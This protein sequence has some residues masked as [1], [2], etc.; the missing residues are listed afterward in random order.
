MCIARDRH[1]LS[2]VLIKQ[3]H[4]SKMNDVTQQAVRREFALLSGA[5]AGLPGVVQARRIV[6]DSDVIY[7]VFEALTGALHWDKWGHQMACMSSSI[8][9]AELFGW[10]RHEEGPLLWCSA[11]QCSTGA[12]ESTC[13]QTPVLAKPRWQHCAT[14]RMLCEE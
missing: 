12:A 13:G 10:Q 7:T 11:L 6:E 3:Y 14:G 2:P 4:K 5:C 9:I 8:H 1:S